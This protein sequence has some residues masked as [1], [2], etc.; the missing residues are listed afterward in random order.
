[1][2]PY[3]ILFSE[4]HASEL[5]SSNYY[6]RIQLT[7]R[8]AIFRCY[9]RNDPLKVLFN[10]LGNRTGVLILKLDNFTSNI[11]RPTTDDQLPHV[12]IKVMH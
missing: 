10:R 1:M 11:R 8:I 3:Y 7:L 12:S 9:R 6:T 5:Q 2:M 4:Q